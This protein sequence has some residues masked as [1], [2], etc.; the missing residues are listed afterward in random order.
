MTLETGLNPV[1]HG[2]ISIL[3]WTG[4]TLGILN[5]EAFKPTFESELTKVLNQ[6]LEIFV[7]M[8]N[9]LTKYN[10]TLVYIQ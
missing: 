7:Q 2:T 1:A 9:D 8:D 10:K 5:V 6:Y 3:K 4:A